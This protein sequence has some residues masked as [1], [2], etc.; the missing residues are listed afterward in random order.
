MGC[1]KHGPFTQSL[2]STVEFMLLAPRHQPR[3]LF[4]VRAGLCDLFPS[5]S[6]AVGS[7]V[8]VQCPPVALGAAG[9]NVCL[10]LLPKV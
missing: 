4:A 5:P 10:D 7:A 3:C 9:S 6:G 2:L 1:A 8:L